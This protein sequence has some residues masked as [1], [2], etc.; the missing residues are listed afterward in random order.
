M[1]WQSSEPQSW[2]QRPGVVVL[3]C[4]PGEARDG[5]VAR[6][7]DERRASGGPAWH[8]RCR[9]QEGGTWAGL[10][11]LIEDLALELRERSPALLSRHAHELCLVVPALKSELAFPQSLTDTVDDQ[12]KTRN[13]AADRAY[14]SLHGLIDLVSEW[15]ELTDPGPWS[16]VC[17]GYDDA[18]ALVH[19]FFAELVRRRGS[20]TGLHVLVVV[21]PGR[22][23]AVAAELIQPA[24]TATVRLALP[25]ADTTVSSPEEMSSLAI[26]LERQLTDDPAAQEAELPRL[27]DAWQRSD[28]PERALRWQMLAMWH[29]NHSGLYEAALTYAGDVE[30][31]LDRLAAEDRKVYFNAVAVLYFCYVPLD[32]G[33]AA[34]RILEPA[35]ARVQDAATVADYCYMLAM[36]HARF[37]DHA[38][39]ARAEGYLQR[40]LSVLAA[41]AA[42]IPDEQRHF[43]TVF[44][45]NGLAFVRLRQGRAQEALELCSAGIIRLNE[46]LDPERHP[47]HRSVLLFNIAQVHAQL[48][49]YEDAIEYFGQ[50]MAMDPNYSEYYND[51]GAVYFKLHRLQEA[52]HDYLRAIALSPP[53]AEVWTNL[54][55]C[56]RAMERMDDAV[57]A[58]SRALDLDPDSPLALVGRADAQFALGRAELALEDYDQAL[59]ME[60]EQPVVLASRA[61]LHYESTRLDE[62]VADLDAAIRLAPDVA[63][64]YQNRAVALRELGRRDEAARDLATYLR[65]SPDAEDRGEVEGS[66]SLLAGTR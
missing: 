1:H 50:A 36:L 6:W 33:D 23:E 22:G 40:A 29:H 10:K 41:A 4:E 54:G 24:I 12:E 62:A 57:H 16:I 60:P 3:E 35:L 5:V 14:R 44:M 48:G 52:E 47:L 58:Y 63:E 20:R 61:I 15:H 7:L 56:Y 42:D 34:R 53:Y 66:L 30:A 17:D 45:M 25:R 13:Y 9:P 21:G 26:E 2:P 59:V 8:L 27:I 43:L 37:L 46:H 39:L 18:N 65:L 32:L 28:S 55:Q 31:E 64:L 49:P 51:R 11:T 38:D 19:R